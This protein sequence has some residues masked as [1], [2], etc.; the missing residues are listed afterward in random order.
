MAIF[1]EPILDF[2]T[3]GRYVGEFTCLAISMV[4]SSIYHMMYFVYWTKHVLNIYRK[5]KRHQ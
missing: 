5:L 3:M 2:K 4:L 1:S